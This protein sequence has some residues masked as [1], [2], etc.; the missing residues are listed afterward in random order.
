MTL[1][2]NHPACHLECQGA[3]KEKRIKERDK[4]DQENKEIPREL[5][6]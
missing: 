4:K 2:N 1:S 5:V 3:C 6:V